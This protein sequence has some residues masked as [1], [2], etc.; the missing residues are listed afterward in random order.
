MSISSRPFIPKATTSDQELPI[1]ALIF[2]C[3]GVIV[4]SEDIHRRAYNATFEHFD[5]RCPDAPEAPVEWTETFYDELQNKVGGGKPK[6][7]WYFGQHGWPTSTILDGKS[8]MT[9]EDQIKLID[10]LQDWK[11]EKYKD[12]I[13]EHLDAVVYECYSIR[14]LNALEQ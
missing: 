4:E 11:T 1:D 6:M 5:V 14:F 9:E 13:G 10:T 8:P 2:D 7:R 12:I 3:D